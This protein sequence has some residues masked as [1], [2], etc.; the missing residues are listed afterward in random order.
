MQRCPSCN[1]TFPDDA[2]GFCPNDG[3]RL[4]GEPETFDPLKTV[5]ATPPRSEGQPPAAPPAPLAPPPNQ[6]PQYASPGQPPPQW[7]PPAGQQP[8]PAWPPP[9]QP[10]N[11]GGYQQQPGQAPGVAYAPQQAAGSK[12]LSLVTL[13]VGLLSFLALCLLMAMAND[14]ISRDRDVI[15]IAY[16]GSAV[17][18]FIA[19]ILGI[20]TLVSSRWRSKWMAMLGLFLGLPAILFFAYVTISRGF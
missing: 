14:L 1:R 6:P 7:Q 3:V 15:E 18:G 20:V 2:P 5:M 10:Q 13:I 4:T 11:W 19:L 17:L 8:P 12:G 16:Y 9:A